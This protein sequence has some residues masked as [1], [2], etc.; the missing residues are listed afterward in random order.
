[1]RNHLKQSL[2]KSKGIKH[3]CLVFA[4][5]LALLPQQAIG[6]FSSTI[7][8]SSAL[9]TR[10]SLSD[11]TGVGYG[12]NFGLQYTVA[13][14]LDLSFD[15]G[16]LVMG[17]K[18]ISTTTY[19]TI[20]IPVMLGARY[21]IEKFY[22]GVEFGQLYGTNKLRSSSRTVE[23]NTEDFALGPVLGVAVPI[24]EKISIDANTKYWITESGDLLSLNV[25]CKV[26]F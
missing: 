2:L 14:N 24:T 25:G 18:N 7:Q 20:F 15:I 10:G 6:Q 1:M 9:P 23:V 8:I 21:S 11:I 5:A 12:A 13:N 16:Y 19:S 4:L 22:L 26:K 3:I 17:D